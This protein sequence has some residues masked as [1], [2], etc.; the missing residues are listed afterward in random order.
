MWRALPVKVTPRTV[1]GMVLLV[2][3]KQSTQ[4]SISLFARTCSVDAKGQLAHRRRIQKMANRTRFVFLLSP[5]ET[6]SV[7]RLY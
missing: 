4:I 1:G 5:L 6:W 7:L 3:E 2:Q